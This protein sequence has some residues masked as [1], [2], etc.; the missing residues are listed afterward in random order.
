MNPTQSAP[1]S[2][3]R[4]PLIHLCSFRLSVWVTLVAAASCLVWPTRVECSDLAAQ[5]VYRK[6]VPSVLTLTVQN[7]DGSTGIGTAFMV[8]KDG[9]AATAWH[10]VR[11]AAHVT[12]RTHD[13]EEFEVSGLIDRDEKRDLA[14]IRVKIFGRPFLPLAKEDPAVGSRAYVIGAPRALEFSISDG[15]ISQIQSIDGARYYQFTCAV[16]PGNSGGPLLDDEERVLGV[17]SWQVKEGQNL[18]FAIPSRY[19][20]GLDA[21]LSTH[22]WGD[23][24]EEAPVAISLD[25]DSLDKILAD[26]LAFAAENRTVL[27]WTTDRVIRVSGG[28]RNGVPPALYSSVKDLA[29]IKTDLDRASTSDSLRDQ[30][31]RAN[32]AEITSCQGRTELTITAIREAQASGGWTARA[33]DYLAQANGISTY[34]R[35]ASEDSRHDLLRLY[36]SSATF[37]KRL[38][39]D[40]AYSIGITDSTTVF[41]LGVLLFPRD[42]L[43]LFFVPKN[44]W[45]F[46]LGLRTGDRIVAAG[47]RSFSR[48]S[49]LEDFK[50]IINSNLGKRLTIVVEREGNRVTLTSKLP[51]EIPQG[52]RITE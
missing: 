13:N 1:Q 38:P 21:T 4:P 2:P 5:E 16:S 47:Q 42:P 51:R 17:V 24:K 22:P 46:D 44:S 8:L 7:R 31:R 29:A 35:G 14:L 9:I 26:A 19:V 40:L 45:A 20:L 32:L 15:L 50:V 34:E 18:N 37:Q 41:R 30:V 43:N 33:N 11:G 39:Q 10:V 25:Q 28:F 48:S 49:T 3:H 12:A 36:H 6:A 23:I 52:S 27:A